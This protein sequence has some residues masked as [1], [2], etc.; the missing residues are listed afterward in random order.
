LELRL[1]D[2]HAAVEAAA[3]EVRRRVRMNEEDAR[4]RGCGGRGRGGTGG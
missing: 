3:V 1:E 4:R 2:N